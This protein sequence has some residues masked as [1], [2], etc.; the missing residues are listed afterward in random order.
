VQI[1]SRLKRILFCRQQIDYAGC[2]SQRYHGGQPGSKDLFWDR[3]VQHLPR[4]LS[5]VFCLAQKVVSLTQR[6]CM[7]LIW[8]LSFSGRPITELRI[9]LR[10]ILSEMH[11]VSLV[12]QFVQISWT[13]RCH[14]FLQFL[15]GI[16]YFFV[17][18]CFCCAVFIERLNLAVRFLPMMCFW[19]C[20]D[21]RS[22]F[23]YSKA[24]YDRRSAYNRPLK[25]SR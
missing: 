14:S 16:H 25:W 6:S 23:A 7:L 12:I 21:Q 11:I 15:I 18:Y 20:V 3:A 4:I 9:A 17:K 19:N 13:F 2:A 8:H 10:Y 22:Y 5:K 24:K 1:V